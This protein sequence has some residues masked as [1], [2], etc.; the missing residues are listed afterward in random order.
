MKYITILIILIPFVVFSQNEKD[1]YNSDLNDSLQKEFD[2]NSVK[3]DTMNL[4]V[5]GI[6]LTGNDV[7]KDWIIT[8]E[9]S[10]KKGS[11]L[12]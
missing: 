6:I 11:R 3:I 7:T 8:R 4:T 12:H 1:P 2:E 5:S 9:M 10:L